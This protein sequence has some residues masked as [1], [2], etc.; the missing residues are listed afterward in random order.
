MFSDTEANSLFS[1]RGLRPL[2]LE[3]NKLSAENIN[4]LLSAILQSGL[5]QMSPLDRAPSPSQHIFREG[6]DR[7]E[8]RDGFKM[9]FASFEEMRVGGPAIHLGRRGQTLRFLPF[10]LSP[11]GFHFL[12]V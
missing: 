12:F 3:E 9:S 5:K 6:N 11:C 10:P 7:P 1:H 4:I 8:S 2:V